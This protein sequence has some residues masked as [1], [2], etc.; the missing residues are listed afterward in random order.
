MRIVDAAISSLEED[1]CYITNKLVSL[2][3]MTLAI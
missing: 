2:I 3:K 1:T